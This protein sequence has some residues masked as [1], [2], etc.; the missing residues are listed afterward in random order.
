MKTKREQISTSGNI[1]FYV[2]IAIV[3]F[4]AL[5]FTLSRQSRNSSSDVLDEAKIEL[6]STQI[7]TYS[8]QVQSVVDQMI[9]SGSDID[10]LNFV[11][12]GESGFNSG[13]H[14]HKVYHPEG[15]GLLPTTLPNEVI[16]QVDTNPVAGWYLGRFNNVEWTDSTNDDVILTAYQIERSICESINKKITGSTA[17]PALS[18]EMNDHLLDTATNNDFTA[19]VCAACEGYMSL[20][21]QNSTRLAF[22]FYTVVADR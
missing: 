21:V 22:S 18:G 20:C 3:L 13:V 17:I 8:R 19:S 10:D 1:L 14:I 9:I 11:Q 5:S 7:I 16:A 12:P 2:L 6:Y 15:G 4:G